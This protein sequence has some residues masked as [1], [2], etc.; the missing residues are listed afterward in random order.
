MLFVFAAVALGIG[1]FVVRWL[2][3]GFVPERNLHGFDRGVA[4]VG[5]LGCLGAIAIVAAVVVMVELSK[6]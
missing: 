3:A 4:M 1:L 5:R 6:P 2:L